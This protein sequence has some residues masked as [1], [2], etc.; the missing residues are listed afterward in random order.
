MDRL[1]AAF[2]TARRLHDAGVAFVLAPLRDCDEHTLR[3]ITADFSMAVFPF[4]V[5]RS[6]SFGE[7]RS[8]EERLTVR[9]LVDEL[10]LATDHVTAVARREDF[11]L[12]CR[13][14]LQ[15]AL[16]DLEDTWDSGP[17]AEPARALLVTTADGDRARAPDGTTRSWMPCAPMRRRS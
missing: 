3:R 7:Q 13:D 14:G 5:G 10:H 11:A 9:A 12:P 8:E 16:T 1:T 17:F 4:V 6:A 15:R 2:E